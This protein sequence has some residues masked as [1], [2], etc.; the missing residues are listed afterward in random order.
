MGVEP[1]LT[2]VVIMEMRKGFW[3]PTVWKKVVL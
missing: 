1:T 2:T 3:R